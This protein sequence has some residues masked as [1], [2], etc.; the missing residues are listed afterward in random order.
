M[1]TVKQKPPP[2]EKFNS[3][4]EDFTSWSERFTMHLESYDVPADDKVKFL[5]ASMGPAPYAVLKRL[6]F[7]KLPKEET[8]DDLIKHL[9]GY[10]DPKPLKEVS[11]V[12]FRRRLQHAN[13]NFASY[14]AALKEIAAGCDFGARLDEEICGQ[15]TAGIYDS[16]LQKQLLGV[17]GLTLTKA[18]ELAKTFELATS[19]Y[20]TIHEN[21]NSASTSA[22]IKSESQVNK[23][24]DQVSK[25]KYKALWKPPNQNPPP[26]QNKHP[27][28][29]SDKSNIDVCFR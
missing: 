4:E 10:Y 13:E 2:F 29:E 18:T 21:D 11:R 9:T 23:I 6:T 17:S 27:V 16:R 5:I 12:K 20:D 7:P 26:N 25:K 28:S 15:I 19:G 24:N 8:F 22:E 14:H 1:A 3:K